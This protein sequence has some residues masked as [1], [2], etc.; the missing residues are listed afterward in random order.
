MWKRMP[1]TICEESLQFTRDE[2]LWEPETPTPKPALLPSMKWSMLR[3]LEFRE[4]IRG[5]NLCLPP[6]EENQGCLKDKAAL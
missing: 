6:W 3:Y 2:G 4:L 1:S 5:K